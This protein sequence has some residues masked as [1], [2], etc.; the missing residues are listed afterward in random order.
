MLGAGV[1]LATG[2][3][4][5]L[6]PFAAIGGGLLAATA[7]GGSVL[8]AVAGHA[9]GGLSRDDLKALGEH[10]DAGQAGLVVVGM[11]DMAA[12]IERAMR[13]A[14]KIESRKLKADVEEIEQDAKAGA[15]TTNE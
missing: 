11:T 9:A 12:K 10:L 7:A 2:L 1:G 15:D 4:V 14:E 6:F 13:R 3:V 5:V 8:G